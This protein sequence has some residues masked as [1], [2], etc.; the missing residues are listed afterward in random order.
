M[1]R[2]GGLIDYLPLLVGSV[3]AATAAAAPMIDLF[4]CQLLGSNIC[5]QSS[6]A[7]R[8]GPSARWRCKGGVQRR[9]VI[10]PCN[11]CQVC[12][13]EA[14]LSPCPRTN[15]GLMADT[16]KGTSSAQGGIIRSGI[17]SALG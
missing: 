14:L 13:L 1:C 16:A 5:N 17:D 10:L 7:G 12:V 3:T 11:R 6:N 4:V 9:L 8:I 2:N 15:I